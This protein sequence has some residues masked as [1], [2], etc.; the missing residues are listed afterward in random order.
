MHLEAPVSS[1]V[2]EILEARGATGT[3]RVLARE[4]MVRHAPRRLFYPA[5]ALGV[6]LARAASGS[7]PHP[8]WWFRRWQQR[9]ESAVRIF[10][11]ARPA[12][13]NITDAK[14]RGGATWNAG[15]HGGPVSSS[16]RCH[17][18]SRGCACRLAAHAVAR[19][20]IGRIMGA[21]GRLRALVH[22]HRLGAPRSA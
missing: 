2:N 13:G 8:A 1:T 6:E 11:L 9:W 18:L 20:A 15:A 19:D 12:Q 3:S 10:A 22:T 7:L 5:R 14:I 16:Y 4:P 17:A 21:H